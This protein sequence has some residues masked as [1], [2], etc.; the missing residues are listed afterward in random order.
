[1][2][3]KKA[4]RRTAKA[5]KATKAAKATKKS[6]KR[7]KK[8][9]NPAELRRD[10]AKMV[11]LEAANMAGAV[12]VEGMKGQL[13]TVKYLF[14]MASIFPAS[15]DGSYATTEEDCLAKT[16]LDRLNLPDKPVGRD[17]EDEPRTVNSWTGISLTADV[18]ESSEPNDGRARLLLDDRLSNDRLS[19]IKPDAGG[20]ASKSISAGASDTVK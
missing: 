18:R 19:D 8:E 5:T 20:E 15:T 9:F 2:T 1:M 7:T 10:I 17:D 4:K 11:G 13:A 16:L 3:K 12:I 6:S 14:E